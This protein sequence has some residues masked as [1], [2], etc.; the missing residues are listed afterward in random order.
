MTGLG[1]ELGTGPGGG[2]AG[3]RISTIK[4]PSADPLLRGMFFIFPPMGVFM[5]RFAL[6]SGGI[7][8]V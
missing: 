3:K 8:R 1:G 4:T 6:E 7:S 5:Q 2:L